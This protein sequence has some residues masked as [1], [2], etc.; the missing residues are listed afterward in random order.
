M[1]SSASE[2]SSS[3]KFQTYQLFYSFR[4][5]YDFIVIPVSQSLYMLLQTFHTVNLLT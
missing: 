2:K 4:R 1:W 3:K 5:R